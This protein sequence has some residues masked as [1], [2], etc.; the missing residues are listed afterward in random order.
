MLTNWFVPKIN[1]S[2]TLN[3]WDAVV[4]EGVREELGLRDASACKNLSLDAKP[5]KQR[6][7]SFGNNKYLN[8]HDSQVR[9]RDPG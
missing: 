1:V 7:A 2:S 9:H 5:E 6:L 3:A 8:T 4:C